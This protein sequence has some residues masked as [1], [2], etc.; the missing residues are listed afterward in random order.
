MQIV[1]LDMSRWICLNRQIYRSTVQHVGC[2]ISLSIAT[3]S[4][5]SMAAIALRSISSQ[6]EFSPLN[7]TM[8]ADM[9]M[10]L[11]P[12]RGRTPIRNLRWVL[13]H[14]IILGFGRDGP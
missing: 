12:V 9:E 8:T 1:P 11:L 3:Q 4:V 2:V 14:V 6:R 10:Q 7:G 13:M 5:G